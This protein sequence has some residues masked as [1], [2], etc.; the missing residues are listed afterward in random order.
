MRERMLAG[1][2]YRAGDPELAAL[3]SVARETMFVANNLPPSR[4]DDRMAMW[5]DLFGSMGDDCAILPPFLCDY[6]CNIYA[7]ARL[8]MNFG[9]IVLDCANVTIGDD[10][11]IAT[12][13]QLVTATHP[14]DPTERATMW[15]MARPIR[16]GHRAWIGAGAIVL[17]GVTVGD[18]A[19]VG[20]GAVV[21]RDVPP[22]TVAVGNPARV[23]RTLAPAD[24]A[25]T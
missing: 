23:I 24:V 25:Q 8:F 5:R 9:C 11:Q 7:G 1:E 21:T 14:L 13:V 15:E 12:A 3:R 6:G 16:I 22:R 4:K 2:L 18:A 19:I 20:A 10:V 17:P